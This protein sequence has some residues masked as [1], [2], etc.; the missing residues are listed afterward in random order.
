MSSPRSRLWQFELWGDPG[1][2]WRERGCKQERERRGKRVNEQVV[3]VDPCAASQWRLVGDFVD[4]GSE[5]FHQG[6]EKAGQ[7]IHQLPVIAT[8][9][10]LLGASASSYSPQHLPC[11]KP[12]KTLGWKGTGT[13]RKKPWASWRMVPARGTGLGP[14]SVW[15][16]VKTKCSIL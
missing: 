16:C 13:C 9:G 7:C 4:R 3:A 15:N 6:S 8:W 11:L 10:L 1:S 5:W 14:S 2:T 12:G